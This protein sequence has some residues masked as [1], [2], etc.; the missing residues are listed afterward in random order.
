MPPSQYRSRVVA[1]SSRTVTTSTQ[2]R[3]ITRRRASTGTNSYRE[4]SLFSEYDDD[5]AEPGARGSTPKPTPALKEAREQSKNNLRQAWEV[6]FTRYSQGDHLAAGRDDVFDFGTGEVVEDAGFLDDFIVE[7]DDQPFAGRSIEI[8]DFGLPGAIGMDNLTDS[9]SED[10][11]EATPIANSRR[12]SVKSEYSGSDDASGDDLLLESSPTRRLRRPIATRQGQSASRNHI[13]R[14]VSMPESIDLLSSSSEDDMGQHDI[15]PVSDRYKE[16]K[17]TR[18]SMK[19]DLR[20][21]REAE[22]ARQAK[23]AAD[24]VKRERT[25]TPF[26]LSPG[27]AHVRAASIRPIPKSAPSSYKPYISSSLAKN[28]SVTPSTSGAQQCFPTPSTST[29]H[30]SVKPESSSSALDIKPFRAA[31]LRPQG[32]SFSLKPSSSN[33]APHSSNS[34][35]SSAIPLAHY[36]NTLYTQAVANE[37][38]SSDDEIAIRTPSTRVKQ[39]ERGASTLPRSWKGKERAKEEDLGPDNVFLNDRHAHNITHLPSPPPSRTQARRK[40]SP[41]FFASPTA[42]TLHPA[43]PRAQSVKPMVEI[44]RSASRPPPAPRLPQIAQKRPPNTVPRVLPSKTEAYKPKQS[45]PLK[46]SSNQL[47]RAAHG[48]ITTMPDGDPYMP[49]CLSSDSSEDEDGDIPLRSLT[50]QNY[51]H[52]RPAS[53]PAPSRKAVYQPMPTRQAYTSPNKRKY[54]VSPEIPESPTSRARLALPTPPRSSSSLQSPPQSPIT[55]SASLARMSLDTSRSKTAISRRVKD[56]T[57]DV[58]SS[59][60]QAVQSAESPRSMSTNMSQQISHLPTPPLSSGSSTAFSNF[61]EESPDVKTEEESFK[62]PSPP[63]KTPTRAPTHT[64]AATSASNSGSNGNNSSRPGAP[65]FD[66]ESDDDDDILLVSPSR[67]KPS[68]KGRVTPTPNSHSRTIMRMANRARAA[69]SVQT[70]RAS[71][72]PSISRAPPKASPTVT[73]DRPPV[74]SDGDESDDPLAI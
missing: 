3:V 38:D 17:R 49:I 11:E 32:R 12:A 55:P 56:E 54:P 10:D 45:S 5:D 71:R 73:K 36:S 69:A 57:P 37:D 22:A 62:I 20:E 41:T 42:P 14:S 31:S 21:F 47:H 35:A 46:G 53:P 72:T 24:R 64:Q 25:C 61:K 63:K 2:K 70:S 52:E 8:G 60:A 29:S 6:I 23:E 18:E 9:S 39:E 7:D 28:S 51:T 68:P 50:T 19:E 40:R 34:H 13:S 15:A 74:E 58:Q 44:F 66:S 30:I 59:T 67:S 1:P 26:L 27:T 43:G 33:S 48:S 16:I 4:D 65:E